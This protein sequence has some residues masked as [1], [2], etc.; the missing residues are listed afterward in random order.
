[1]RAR[2]RARL[3][4]RTWGRGIAACE[5]TGTRP[6]GRDRL[7]GWHRSLH[8]GDVGGFAAGAHRP[9]LPRTGDGVLVPVGSSWRLRTRLCGG[10]TRGRGR[11]FASRQAIVFARSGRPR[12]RFLDT[13][14]V[15][16]R[17]WNASGYMRRGPAL[18]LR[19]WFCHRLRHTRSP[20]VVRAWLLHGRSGDRGGHAGGIYFARSGLRY[21]LFALMHTSLL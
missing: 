10:R 4:A 21:P 14:A 7:S 11:P 20:G 16:G 12:R 18:P 5:R 3:A 19:R 1:M 6:G 8:R 17:H 9:A 15:R 2:V 13:R